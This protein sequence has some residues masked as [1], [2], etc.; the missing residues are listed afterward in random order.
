[1]QLQFH[2]KNIRQEIDYGIYIGGRDSGD[3]RI[4]TGD[5]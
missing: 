4:F 1:M 2:G 3:Y 5:H